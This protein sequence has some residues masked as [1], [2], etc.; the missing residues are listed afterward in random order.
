ME[1]KKNELRHGPLTVEEKLYIQENI[2]KISPSTMARVLKR[3]PRTIRMWIKRNINEKDTN[4]KIAAGELPG[5]VLWAPVQE[6]L[7]R[8]EQNRFKKMWGEVLGQFKGDVLFTEQLQIKTMLLDQIYM[9]RIGREKLRLY[10]ISSLLEKKIKQEMSLSREEQDT[11]KLDKMHGQLNSI[12]G[13]IRE[14]D[15]IYDKYSKQIKQA[16]KDLKATRDQRLKTASDAKKDWVALIKHLEENNGRIAEGDELAYF[17]IAA[18]KE[19]QKLGEYHQYTDGQVERPIL[20]Y[21][22]ISEE[23][24]IE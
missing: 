11:D 5:N 2:D 9:D 17:N 16:T 22:T 24:K 8:D 21:E 23:D 13:T 1:K 6:Q 15:E 20:S 19:K 3:L 12:R 4:P 14:K 10:H 18:E 7:T